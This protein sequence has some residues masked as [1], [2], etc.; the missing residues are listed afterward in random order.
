MLLCHTSHRLFIAHTIKPICYYTTTQLLQLWIIGSHTQYW[1][2]GLLHQQEGGCIPNMRQRFGSE[3]MRAPMLLHTNF[4]ICCIPSFSTCP[5]ID[6]SSQNIINLSL[7]TRGLSSP[8]TTLPQPCPDLF[9]SLKLGPGC[10]RS[11]SK[12]WLTIA[13]AGQHFYNL[14]LVKSASWYW[15]FQCSHNEK[16]IAPLQPSWCWGGND[17]NKKNKMW[18][19]SKLVGQEE[20]CTTSYPAYNGCLCRCWPQPCSK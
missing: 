7:P 5:F 11:T 4:P 10:S 12:L 17:I 3:S 14:Y 15:R 19:P 6:P 2:W 8:T 1:I 18:K 9:T 20:K 16:K 13:Q